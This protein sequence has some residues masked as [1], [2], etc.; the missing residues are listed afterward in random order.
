MITLLLAGALFVTWF[1]EPPA[2]SSSTPVSISQQSFGSSGQNTGT[3]TSSGGELHVYVA[4][5]IKHPGVYIL[6]AGARVYQLLQAAGGASPQADLVSL[7][8]AAPLTAPHLLIRTLNQCRAEPANSRG[9]K[10]ES[11]GGT[12]CYFATSAV[13]AFTKVAS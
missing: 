1:V 4:G 13:L 11:A 10:R 6:P 12:A 8:L 3:S 9:I 2:S 7:N 5:S